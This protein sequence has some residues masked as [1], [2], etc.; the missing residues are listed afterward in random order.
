[1]IGSYMAGSPAL[2]LLE[3][4]AEALRDSDSLELSRGTARM[5]SPAGMKTKSMLRDGFLV[6]VH[7]YDECGDKRSGLLRNCDPR[8]PAAGWKRTEIQW[9]IVTFGCSIEQNVVV[10]LHT[11]HLVHQ[12]SVTDLWPFDDSLGDITAK[13]GR[14]VLAIQKG[15][16]S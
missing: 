11:C 1:M 2:A 5:T 8:S 15:P 4:W 14:V 6:V 7:F 16:F 12:L 13:F 9:P 10:T 3:R